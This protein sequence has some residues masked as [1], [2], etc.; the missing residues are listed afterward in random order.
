MPGGG[1]AATIPAMNAMTT[2]GPNALAS[3]FRRISGLSPVVRSPTNEK[4]PRATPSSNAP[5]NVPTGRPAAQRSALSS[6]I[7]NGPSFTS[8]TAM[9]APNR[10]VATPTPSA[11]SAAAKRR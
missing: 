6:Q 7:V 10:P 11:P 5:A 9:A 2:H 1:P 8:S 3:A 4:T